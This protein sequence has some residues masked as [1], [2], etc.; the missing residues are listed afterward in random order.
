MRK[1]TNSIPVFSYIL[2]LYL[3]VTANTAT[4]VGSLSGVVTEHGTNAV[5]QGIQVQLYRSNDPNS[6]TEDNAYIYVT[7]TTTNANG[8]YSVTDLEAR[9]YRIYIPMASS[10]VSGRYFVEANLYSVQIFDNTE[11]P[12]MNLQL[13]EAGF[14]GGYVWTESGEPIPGARVVGRGA[15]F[16]DGDEDHS[17]STDQNGLYILALLPSTGEFYEISVES[18]S[19]GTTQYA[20]QYAPDLYQATLQGTHGPDFTLFE[21][22]CI[23]GRI[24]NDQG[25]GIPDVEVDTVIGWINDPESWTDSNGYYTLNNL[26]ATNQAYVT[27]D[28]DTVTILNGVRYGS[29]K[30]FVGPLT[31]TPGTSCAQAPE[32]VIVEAGTIEGVVTDTAGT[33]I[34]ATEVRVEGFDTDGNSLDHDALTD[35]FGQYTFDFLPPGEY[36]VKAR[37]DGWIMTSQSTVIVISGELTDV[38]LVLNR[39]IQGA[40]ISGNVIDFQTNTCHKD[41]AGILLPNFNH[42]DHLCENGI[43]AI[44]SDYSFRVQES[45]TQMVLAVT[46]IADGYTD[47]FEPPQPPEIVGDYQIDL[48]PGITD[49]V[50][51]SLYFTD[52]G[53]NLIFHDQ[54]RWNL[55]AGETL[56]DQ[57]FQL[58]P[59]TDTGVLEGEINYP[60]SAWFNPYM[61]YIIALNEEMPSGF[62]LG[63]ALAEPSLYPTYRFSMLPAGRYTLLV[64]SNGF[65]NQTYHGVVVASGA[66]TLQDINLTT[67]ATLSGL[68]TDAATG[69]PL[70]GARIEITIGGST[71]VSDASGA[72]TVSGLAPNDYS[73][74]VT[75]PGYAAFNGVVSVTEPTTSFDIAL[76]SSVGSISGHVLDEYGAP[77]NAAQVVA[78]NPALNSHK[79]VSTVAGNFTVADLP[80]DD[81]VLGIK[82][83][84]YTTVQY[85]PTGVVTLN[86]NQ[87]LVITDAIVVSPSAPLF[88]TTST[89]SEAMGVKTLSVSIIS[90]R[91]LLSMP[92]IVARGRDTT[93][94]CGTFNWQAVTASKYLVS[95]EVAAGESLVWIDVTEGVIPV[96]AG[97]PA[98]ATFSFEVATELLESS[99]TNLFNSIGGDSTIM[100]TQD[101]TNV[102]IPPFALTG[103]DTQAVKLIVE[104]YGN[105][106]DPVTNNNNQPVSAVYDFFFEEDGVEVDINHAVTITLQFQKPADMTEED[107]EADLMIGFFRV[108]DQQWVYHTDPDSGISNV[109]INW[110]NNTIIF[111]TSHFTRFAAFLSAIPGDFDGDGVDN[112]LD[113]CPNVANSSQS[114]FDGDGL[115][116]A[117]D[118]DIDNDGIA[119]SGDLCAETPLGETVDPGTGCT[120]AQ[121]C[122]CDGPS[123]TNVSWINQGK[124]VSCVARN[125]EIFVEL[126][127]I[128][129]A[130][131]DE[132]VSS[133]AQS[134]C[135]DTK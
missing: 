7:T 24:V 4:A 65:V 49:G 97:N 118:P 73:L 130:E 126:E 103:T 95:C 67:G 2:F 68:I 70:A 3:F 83:L 93:T 96:I 75:K 58:P 89:V 91:D 50:L 85:P 74:L 29:S 111:D 88:D 19:L 132:I 62:A 30:R 71:S 81:Y 32:M 20:I 17:V 38:D 61:T 55:V 92:T 127:L 51:Y 128:T 133:A 21:G 90:D 100:G 18:A 79:I 105:P 104:R 9:Q 22:G 41:S 25:I 57:D 112:N 80:A 43:I 31:V 5:L 94:G 46:E 106:G 115:G 87:S 134:S 6:A 84:G 56:T 23:Q 53:V 99:T 1:S 37:K 69:L 122:P 33:P 8:E 36:T 54:Q 40:S 26:P 42:Y 86:P 66:T 121:L 63:D 60:A 109:H 12:N 52:R 72:Y 44:P 11:T 10:D 48:P 113:N 45:V 123:G 102:Y 107:F 98:S 119:N 28:Q 64:L 78:Y 120:I 135:G 124:Y 39:S 108:S 15:W 16:E 114:D 34:V 76:D 116:D 14:I 117:C 110:L 82:A 125:S 59:N 77:V 13:R 131:K 27:I 35:A 47:F 101:K 129:E